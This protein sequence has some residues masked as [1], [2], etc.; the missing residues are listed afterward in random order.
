VRPLYTVSLKRSCE[1]EL[2]LAP[3]HI[4][5][6]FLAAVVELERGP[7]SARPGLDI[8]K[9]QGMVNTWRLRIG[10]YRAIFE[11]EGS[12]ITFTVLAHR[13]NAY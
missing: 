6:R 7:L 13:S 11:V 5:E 8:R 12:N 10:S 4:R 3:D 2:L 1:R 9:L